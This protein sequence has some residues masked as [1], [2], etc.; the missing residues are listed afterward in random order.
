MKNYYKC[1]SVKKISEQFHTFFGVD[2]ELH[3]SVIQDWAS[4]FETYWTVVNL[5]KKSSD[6]FSH[7]GRPSTRTQQ[8][9]E[10]VQESVERS[11]KRS[12]RRRSQS[13]NLSMLTCRKLI[14]VDWN[15]Y[16]YLVHTKQKLTVVDKTDMAEKGQKF[17]RAPHILD[18]SPKLSSSG[19]I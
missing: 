13:L 12:L 2:R 5:N 19:V 6:R 10:M 3:K 11:P 1:G 16:P 4:N 9:V 15:K 8:I 17:E 18:F 7:S 14:V